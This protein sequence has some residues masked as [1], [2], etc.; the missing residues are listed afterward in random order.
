MKLTSRRSDPILEAYQLTPSQVIP[1]FVA[2]ESTDV[3]SS[4]TSSETGALSSSDS[5][6]SSH[7]NPFFLK[8]PLKKKS[9][10]KTDESKQLPTEYQDTIESVEKKLQKLEITGKRIN[11]ADKIKA[12]ND[13][14]GLQ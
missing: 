6:S 14:S 2:M 1:D 12:F 5:F 7:G 4:S 9:S 11:I 8:G 10:K 13:N 3:L